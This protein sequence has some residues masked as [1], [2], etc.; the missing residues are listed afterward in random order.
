M[1]SSYQH[2]SDARMYFPATAAHP[3]TQQKA[4]R[5]FFQTVF[6]GAIK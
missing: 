3:L 2:P 1:N 5:H 6:A 4:M